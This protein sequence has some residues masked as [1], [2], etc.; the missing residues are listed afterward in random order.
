MTTKK[1][2]PEGLLGKKLGMTQIFNEDGESIPVTV[3][4][5]GPC[6]IL[7]VKEQET[8]GYSAVQLGFGP[9]KNQ[10]VNK[11]LLG[12]FAKTGKG[13]F[14]FVKELR[15]DTSALGWTT[16]GQELRAEQV[17]GIGD[18]VDVTGVSKGRGFSGVFRRHHMKGQPATRGTHETKRST[19]AIGCRKTPGRVMKNKRMPGQMGAENVTMQ[20]LKVVA[21]MPEDNVIL[22]KGGIPGSKGGLIVIRKAVKSN[23]V[24]QAA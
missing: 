9:K 23:S 20:N 5:V 14:Y 2:H 1:T 4:Q 12:H 22:V 10:R 13:A 17:F 6:Y 8:H 3:V 24:K 18:F 15:C 21:V 7:D 11:P 16:L 19:G